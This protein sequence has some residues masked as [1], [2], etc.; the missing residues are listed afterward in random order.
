ML[1]RNYWCGKETNNVHGE[2][3]KNKGG[4]LILDSKTGRE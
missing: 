4:L 3:I 1:K 2:D